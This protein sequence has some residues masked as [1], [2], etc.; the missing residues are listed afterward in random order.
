MVKDKVLAALEAHRGQA[1]SGGDLAAELG[2]SRNAVWKAVG[3]LRGEGHAIDGTPNRGYCLATASAVLSRQSIEKYL[4]VPN[5]SVEVFPQVTSTNTV[6]R[7]QAEAGAPEGTVLLA[8]EQTEGRGRRGRT[9][10]SPPWAGLYISL[11]LR[12]S[13][14]AAEAL[15]ITTC[16]AVAVAEAIERV[17]GVPAEIKWVNDVFCRGKK[18]CGILTEA[19]LDL[20]SGGLRY[21]V[22]GMGLNVLPPPEGFPSELAEVAGSILLEPTDDGDFRN[23][24]AAEILNGFL[25]YYPNLKEKPF[26]EAY[27][28]RSLILGKPIW[29]LEPNRRQEAFALNLDRDFQ[30]Q[31]RLA[32][33]ET[34]TLSAG[35]VSVRTIL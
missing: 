22:L 2:V 8:G 27:R 15:S 33:G 28:N 3:Q 26:F 19:A 31:V 24:L 34:R 18:V 17:A 30:L 1:V 25:S 11:L 5:L 6:L 16:A 35:E 9:F 12:P 32:N 29:I 20:E 7:E 10:Y 4:S 13:L 23:R 14:P 21:A